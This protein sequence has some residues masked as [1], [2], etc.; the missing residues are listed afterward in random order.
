MGHKILL[1]VQNWNF[2]ILSGLPSA[3]S[4]ERWAAFRTTDIMKYECITNCYPQINELRTK[5]AVFNLKS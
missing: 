4:C 1:T 5:L 2:A 3:I